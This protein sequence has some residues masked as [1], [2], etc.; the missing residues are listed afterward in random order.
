MTVDL[1]L[2][3][4]G[5]IL[6]ECQRQGLLRNETA[7]VLATAYWETA[8][9]MRPVQEAFWLSDEWRRTNLRY[10]PWHGRGYVQLTWEANYRRAGEKLGMDLTRDPS[11]VMQPDVAAQILVRGMVEGWFTGKKLADY[12]TLKASDYVGARRIVNGTDKASAIAELA[13]DYEGALERTG[14]G[15]EPTPPVANTK[16]DGTPPRATPARSKTIW[17]QIMQ[18]VGAYGGGAIAWFQAEDA[19]VRRAI[20][21]GGCIVAAAGIVVFRERLLKWMEGVR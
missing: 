4:T 19:D 18:W 7:Y 6:A 20:I 5:L 1:S 15:V 17:A 3:D 12:L 13:R 16:R 14:Y 9:T 2:G 8:Q 10:Y 21:I 11:V